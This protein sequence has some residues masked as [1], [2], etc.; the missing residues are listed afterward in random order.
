VLGHELGHAVF[1]LAD[2]ARAR[3]RWHCKSLAELSR[4]LRKA[5]HADRA[6]IRERMGALSEQIDAL[7]PP[8]QAA[9]AEVWRELAA[10]EA[11]GRARAASSTRPWPG[12][13]SRLSAE[14][15]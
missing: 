6:G 12:T 3:H 5:K 7:E 14:V 13:G 2:P 9:E 15:D 1:I 11:A 4:T 8:A 10:S